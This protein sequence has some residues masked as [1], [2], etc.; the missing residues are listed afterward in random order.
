MSVSTE[1]APS[2]QNDHDWCSSFPVGCSSSDRGKVTLSKLIPQ[3]LELSVSCLL[4]M[5]KPLGDA[6]RVAM[7]ELIE[8]SK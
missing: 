4:L 1:R 7:L 6:M 3:P 8:D 2:L 5:F